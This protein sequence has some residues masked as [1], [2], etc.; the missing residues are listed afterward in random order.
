MSFKQFLKK[1]TLGD[2]RERVSPDSDPSATS[3]PE[4]GDPSA[5]ARSTRVLYITGDARESRIVSGAFNHSHPH[6]EFD[7]SIDLANVRAHL[8]SGRQHDALVV[9][10]SVPGEEAFSLIG[11]AR[12][13]G[14]GLPIVAAAEQSLELYR[15]AGADECVR[16]GGS[17]LSR[18][19]MAIEDAIKKRPATAT[20][21]TPAP[22]ARTFSPGVAAMRVAFAGDI[23]RMRQ[24]VDGLTPPLE[25]VPLADALKDSDLQPGSSLFDV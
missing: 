5:S 7:F 25:C 4:A 8:A 18:L 16:K 3:S 11:Y 13:H 15:Q 10:W 21:V 14:A 12:E 6:L 24:S 2:L 20:P 23:D 22:V 17:F 9:G 19:P 1:G